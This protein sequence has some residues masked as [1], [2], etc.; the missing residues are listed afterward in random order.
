MAEVVSRMDPTLV[1]DLALWNA[2]HPNHPPDEQLSEPE[3]QYAQELDKR[4]QAVRAVW[5]TRGRDPR[6]LPP[7]TREAL[8]YA[9]QHHRRQP[10]RQPEPRH[11]PPTPRPAPPVPYH[12][13]P[14]GRGVSR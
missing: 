6:L 8:A 1:N 14:P 5:L 7:A 13:P 9:D 3:R 12:R 2:T 10:T 4:T 11:T